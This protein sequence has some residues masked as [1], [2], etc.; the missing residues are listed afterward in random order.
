LL[1]YW[2]ERPKPDPQEPTIYALLDSPSGAGA[3]RFLLRPGVTTAPDV[4][5]RLFFRTAVRKLGLAP[6]TSMLSVGANQRS[7]SEEPVHMPQRLAV[8][9][10]GNCDLGCGLSGVLRMYHT[11]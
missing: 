6:L 5:A 3:Y 9:G 4:D 1:E 11:G 2:I 8:E 7:P 10:Y